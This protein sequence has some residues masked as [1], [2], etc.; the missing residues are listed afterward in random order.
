MPVRIFSRFLSLLV[1]FAFPASAAELS[2]RVQSRSE[3][4]IEHALVTDVKDDVKVYTDHQGDFELRCELPCLLLVTHPRFVEL[5]IEV[6]EDMAA[7]G[8]VATL[9]PKQ[10][11]FAE[12]VV[13]ASRG[14]GDA[15]APVA[16][17]STV[18][19]AGEKAAAPSTLTELIEGVP[20]VAENG[21]GGL[22][23]V[24]SIRGVSRQ[25]VMTLV[26][27]M[28]IVGERRAGVSTSFIDPLLMGSVDVL[29]GPASTFYGS[30]ALGGVIQV[31]PKQFETSSVSL[32]YSSYG[33]ESYQVAG[34]G[35]GKTSLGIAHRSRSNGESAD[36]AELDDHF[37]QLSATL[38]HRWKRQDLSYQILVLPAFGRDIGKS[39]TD[40]P[41]RQTEY[42]EDHLLVKFA[43]ESA[44]GWNLDV[45]AHPNS[46][47]TE[48]FEERSFSRVENDALDLGLSFQREMRLTGYISG[49]Y[50]FDYVGRRGVEAVE[51]RENPATGNQARQ[52]TLDGEQ[53]EVAAFASISWNWGNATFQAGGRST[54]QQQSNHGAPSLEDSALT[55]FLGMVQPVGGG[56]ELVLNLGT[57]LRFPN[58]S[59]RFF[60]GTTGRGQTL[61]NPDLISESAVNADLGLRWYGRHLFF[62]AQLFQLD[63]E[64]YIER[65]D[66]NEDLRTFVNLTS[67][68]VQGLELEGFYKIGE[69]WQVSW[70]GHLLNSENRGRG[71]RP[72]ADVPADRLELGVRFQSGRWES[73]LSYQHRAQKNNPGSGEKA[74]VAADL[75][76]LALD[77]ELTQGLVLTLRGRNLLG[78]LY[79]NAAD[80]KAPFAA[81]RSVGLGLV[82]QR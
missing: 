71:R 75:V 45:W 3:I 5:P 73:R 41:E 65:V 55:G 21:Q 25:R 24:F 79:W 23:Q 78:E 46:L 32:G 20:G 31:F 57:G 8:L 15:F 17:A 80:R 37:T 16:I 9:E 77:V 27:G 62:A 56:L 2:G 68:R 4:P 49:R 54:W 64:D 14:G 29:R 13:T 43:V 35:D 76:S 28:R 51:V 19:H 12:V 11:I 26:D 52:Q 42:Q 72:L 50:G 7:A 30:G 47:T 38:A 44:K 1:F 66:L 67:G 81:G 22:F 33:D 39:S 69:R 36:G 70:S 82:W 10:E 58:L 40:F 48:V 59:E 18:I 6:D 63:I 74:I 34:W 60:T 53:D 61:G